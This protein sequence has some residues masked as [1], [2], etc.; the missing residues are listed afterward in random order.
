MPTLPED[1]RPARPVDRRSIKVKLDV[2]NHASIGF[3]EV[4]KVTDLGRTIP[5]FDTTRVHYKQFFNI[6][7]YVTERC[8]LRC[9]HCYMGER[10]ERG[11]MMDT[12]K[13]V[14]IMSA[15]R[16]IGAEYVTILGGEPTLHPGLGSIIEQAADL[17]FSQI[18]IDTNGIL[19]KRLLAIPAGILH[20][21]SISVDGASSETHDLVRGPGTFKKTLKGIRLLVENGYPVRVNY[22]VCRT[23]FHEAS[24][25][26]ELADNLGVKLVNFHT[27]SEEGNGVRNSHLSLLPY[28]WIDFYENLERLRSRFQVAIWYPPTWARIDRIS[29]YVGEGFRGCLGC[30]LDRLSIFPD[31]RCYVCSVLFDEAKHFATLS[32]D[33]FQMNKRDNEFDLFSAAMYRA[34]APWLSG[35]PAEEILENNG[36]APTPAGLVSMCRCWKSQ[37]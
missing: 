29:K 9:K 27:F 25:M 5:S 20:Y 8:Q 37:A 14:E 34:E 1:V 6:F 7:L 2:N 21:V 16:K 19:A 35:C 12:D 28:E 36:K 4:V 26:L 30:S 15:C 11:L 3:W 17:G 24:A 18:T 33:G 31:G 10:L 22:T 13:A 32:R 23:N